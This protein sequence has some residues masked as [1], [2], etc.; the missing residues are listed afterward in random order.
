MICFS[1]KFSQQHFR[2]YF[3]RSK[4]SQNRYCI[5][6]GTGQYSCSN[7]T[8]GVVLPMRFYCSQ[9]NNVLYPCLLYRHQHVFMWR[10]DTAETDYFGRW[11]FSVLW[12]L[13]YKCLDDHDTLWLRV[14]PWRPLDNHFSVILPTMVPTLTI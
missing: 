14:Y 12:F 4:T 5:D 3:L 8:C 9:H 10:W 2:H 13:L 11:W 7:L 6:N 1:D